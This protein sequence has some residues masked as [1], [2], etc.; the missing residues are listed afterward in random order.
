MMHLDFIVWM[1]TFPLMVSISNYIDAL[2]NKISNKDKEY[3]SEESKFY[4]ALL[5]VS[6]WLIVGMYLF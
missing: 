2:K 4:S 1:I 3:V 5:I 6:I